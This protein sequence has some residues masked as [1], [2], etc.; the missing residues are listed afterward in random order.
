M[1][2][3]A[4]ALAFLGFMLATGDTHAADDFAIRDGDTVVFLGD[5]ITAARNYTRTVENYVL[6]RYPGRIPPVDSEVIAKTIPARI[7]VMAQI[8]RTSPDL[9]P[10]PPVPDSCR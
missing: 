3:A 7:E 8:L 1:R 6:L 2:I 4:T 9:P 5:S 10:P